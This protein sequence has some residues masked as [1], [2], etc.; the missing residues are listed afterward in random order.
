MPSNEKPP[1][2]VAAAVQHRAYRLLNPTHLSNRPTNI[3][4]TPFPTSP[5]EMPIAQAISL[6]GSEPVHTTIHKELTN[7]FC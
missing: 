5:A 2:L 7:A 6:Y 4:P 3:E 1:T